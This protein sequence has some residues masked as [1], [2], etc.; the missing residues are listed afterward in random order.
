MNRLYLTARERKLLSLLRES[1]DPIPVKLLADK[2]TVSERTIHRDLK[3]LEAALVDYNLSIE[4]K[5]RFGIRMTGDLGKLKDLDQALN[6][7]GTVS[8]YTPEER[9]AIILASL[10]QANEPIKLFTLSHDLNVTIATVSHDL[11]Q[12]EKE[13]N[14]YQLTLIR[15]RGYG[16]E[17]TG[18]EVDKRAAISYLINRYVDLFEYVPLIKE[19][20]KQRTQP[21]DAVSNRLLG[22]VNLE[23]LSMIEACVQEASKSLPYELADNAYVGLVVHL[24]LAIERLQQGEII[25]FDQ[26]YPRKEFEETKEYEVAAAMLRNLQGALPIEIP[27]EE[28][29]YITMHLLGA[30][31]RADQAYVLEDSN[32]DIVYRAKQ[33]IAYIGHQL[34]VDLTNNM[35]LL[36]DLVTH[37][38]PAIYRLKQGMTIKNPI[39]DEIASKYKALIELLREGVEKIFPQIHFPDDEIGY[40]VL[41]FASVLLYG[42]MKLEVRAL[43]ICSSGIGTAKLLATTLMQ[44]IPE[45]KEVDNKSI[46]DL[47]NTDL[48]AYDVIVSTVPLKGYDVDYVLASPMLSQAEADRVKKKIRQKKVTYTPSRA[49]QPSQQTGIDFITKLESR[50]IYTTTVLQLLQS[51][52][53]E[54]VDDNLS[55][56]QVLDAICTDL[57][58]QG[59]VTDKQTVYQK[60]IERAKQSGLGIPNTA[61]ALYHT[62]SNDV[63]DAVFFIYELAHPV[64]VQGMDGEDMQ[65]TRLLLMAAPQVTHKEV[66]EVLSFLSS[67]IIIQGQESI[68]R[69]ELG[70]EIELKNFLSEQFQ[71]FLQDKNIH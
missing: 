65:I 68:D 4:K 8:E 40:L 24:A 57:E 13:L 16:V 7:G 6:N 32:L 48:A 22:F 43:V 49:R 30:K 15:K 9:K 5:T 38:R 20:M 37:M 58:K 25:M 1:K 69:F 36:N 61:L 56:E 17:I 46:F 29:D 39:Y 27:H 19:T 66:L 23:N 10:L 51:F 52:H 2:L 41:H 26:A 35:S 64:T 45:I 63:N 53:I 59:Y 62:R 34:Q 21:L 33:L 12:M 70:K 50:Q 42:E 44:R 14:D 67:L 54:Q 71:Q 28:I 31:L 55:L 60:L 3:S 47:S 11:D 18:N